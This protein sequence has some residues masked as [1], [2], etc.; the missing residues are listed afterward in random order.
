MATKSHAVPNRESRRGE[1]GYSEATRDKLIE[2]AG[3]VFAEQGYYAATIREICMRAGAN[4]AAVNYH[5]HDKLGLYTEVLQQSVRA[6]KLEPMRHALDGNGPPEEMLRKVIRMRLQ[7]MSSGAVSDCQFRIMAHEFAR[8]TPAMPRIINK[9]SRPLYLRFLE[10]VGKIIG[11][12][13]SHEK[14]RLCVHSIMGQITLYVMA[15]PVLER[16]WP[17]MDMTPAQVERIADHIADFSLAYLREIRLAHEQTPRAAR[18]RR[19]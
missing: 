8:P 4:V 14:T 13:P 7:A 1:S 6:A 2:V 3:V 19:S 9:V 18:T 5:F 16:L 11:M 10:L 12:P 17:E 15:R